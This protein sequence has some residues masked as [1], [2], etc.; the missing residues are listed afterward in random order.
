MEQYYGCLTCISKNAVP[1]GTIMCQK[2]M[3]IHVK[4]HNSHTMKSFFV[5]TKSNT[6]C[7]ICMVC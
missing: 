3:T 6:K 5:N 2:C 7:D 4:Q 1:L